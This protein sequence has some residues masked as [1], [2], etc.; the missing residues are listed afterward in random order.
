M[1]E[2]D[3]VLLNVLLNS[4]PSKKFSMTYIYLLLM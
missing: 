2:K 1:N 4:Y 3:H